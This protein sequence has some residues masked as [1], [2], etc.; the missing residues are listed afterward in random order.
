MPHESL[1]VLLTGGAG[2]IGSALIPE[3]RSRGHDVFVIDNLSFGRRE[4]ADVTADHFFACDI[5]D[6][7]AVSRIVA[8]VDPRWIVHLAAI[9]FLP[10]CNANPVETAFVNLGGTRNLLTAARALPNLEKLFFA[11]TAAVYP[12]CDVAVDEN[13]P[14][15]PTDIYGLS[16]LLGE[17]LL[18]EFH[19]QTS[20]PTIICRFFNAF[21]PNET[22]P[23]LIPEIQ[24]QV[25][26]GART[27]ALGNLIPK[28]DFVHTTD[29]ADA[30]LKLLHS[31]DSGISIFNLGRGVEYSVTEVVAAF[32]AALGEPLRIEVD[33]ARVRRSERLHL[34]ADISKLKE[35][36]D[37]EPRVGLME[38]I[39][40]L[41]GPPTRN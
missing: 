11:S 2:F 27:L 15:A 31:V 14:V 7:D 30:I 32:E 29:M 38:G 41:V 9:H 37:W 16:K 8:H 10:Y 5:R 19:L 36:I 33:P 18:N 25:N 1:P 3:I 13:Y 12:V 23:H 35:A 40:T 24:R 4:L 17:H 26:S 22:N 20:V 28:R 39:A 21:G 6:A 34:L